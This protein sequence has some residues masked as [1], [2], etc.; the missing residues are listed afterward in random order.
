[1]AIVASRPREFDGRWDPARVRVVRLGEPDPGMPVI[2][3]GR[4]VLLG[5]PDAWQSDWATLAR[6]R[7]D[8]PIV[9]SGCAVADVRAI[10]RIREVP[11]PVHPGEVWLVEHGRAR[12]ALLE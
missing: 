9:F 3:P 4:S 10:A 11:P 6:A 12:R 7:R 1:V 5:D 2:D 8:L